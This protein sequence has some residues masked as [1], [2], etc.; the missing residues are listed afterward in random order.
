LI[1]T[2]LI[3]V[4]NKNGKRKQAVLFIMRVSLLPIFLAICGISCAF[5]NKVDG[6]EILD[7]KVTLNLPAEEI[8]AVLK[9]LAAYAEVGFTYSN[10]ILPAKQK[11]TLIAN[12]ERLGDLL[13][14]IFKPFGISFEV[15]GKQIVLTKPKS[16]NTGQLEHGQ[17]GIKYLKPIS[18]TV[19]SPDGTRLQG[20][21][22]T[23]EGTTRGTVTDENGHFEIEAN[24][25]DV[26][27]FSSVGYNSSRFKVGP[28][29]VINISLTKSQ[30]AMGEV[31]VT[32]LGI[33]REKKS[34]GYSV[35]GISGNEVASSNSPNVL[36]ALH[37]KMASVIVTDANGD[38]SGTTRIVMRG[39]NN[40]NPVG[41][42][43]P[44]IVVDGVPIN[45]DNSTNTSNGLYG[46][47]SVGS[48]QDWGSAINNINAYDIDSM[49]TL[50]GP[51]AA[52][53]YGERGGN[54]AIIINTKRGS[55]KPGLGLDYNFSYMG[56][57]IYKWQDF[58]NEF[59]AGPG[60]NQLIYSG[61]QANYDYSA[62]NWGPLPFPTIGGVQTLPYMSGDPSESWGPKLDGTSVKWWDGKMH[63]FSPIPES[64]TIRELFRNGLT[65][66]HN[67]SFSG[68]NDKGSIRVSLTRLDNNSVVPNSG[69][70]QTTVNL[71]GS[72]SIS[73]KVKADVAVTYIDVERHNAAYT[74]DDY[75]GAS[76]VSLPKNLS[77]YWP[78]GY[79][80][81]LEKSY[82]L[83]DGSINYNSFP[84]SF[85]FA[86]Q[87]GWFPYNGNSGASG[88]FWNLYNNNTDQ[89]QHE[90]LGS[91]GLTYDILPWLSLSG[92]IG[93]DNINM[94]YET[95]NKP[96]DAAGLLNGFYSR[97]L[98]RDVSNNNDVLLTF[99]KTGIGNLL[100]IKAS[101][102]ASNWSRDYYTITGSSGTWQFANYY[103]V[104]NYTGTPPVAVENYGNG[105]ADGPIGNKLINSVYGFVD[106]GYKGF[107]YLDIT[108]RNDWSSTLPSSA[109]SYFFPSVS[110][111]FVF[112]ELMHH[113]PHWLSF[114]KLR[115]SLASAA[116]D[117]PSY[118]SVNSYTTGS[119]AGQ[120][121]SSLQTTVPALTLKPQTTQSTELGANLAL[122]HNMVT[123]DLTYYNTRASNQILP[124]PIAAS[125]G[126]GQLTTNDGEMLNTGYTISINATPVQSGGF[127]WNVGLNMNHN[128]SKVVSISPYADYLEEGNIWGGYGPAIAA[129]AGDQYGTIYGWDYVYDPSTNKPILDNNGQ[130]YQSTGMITSTLRNGKYYY[131]PKGEIQGRVPV[132]NITPKFT[133][134]FVTSLSYK[135]FSLGAVLDI[136]VGGDMWWGD[137]GTAMTQGLS[138]RTLYEREGHGLPWKV[139][140]PASP[141]F[142]QSYNIGV[143]LPGVTPN[144][145]TP[146]SFQSNSNVVNYIYKYAVYSNWGS[147][148][149][150]TNTV[151]D[152]SWVSLRELN[153]RYDLPSSL[154]SHLKIFQSFSVS[155]VGRNLLY[156]YNS[157]PDHINPVS[158]GAGNAQGIE[159]GTM[160][161]MRSYGF[162]IHAGF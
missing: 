94:D 111:S 138:P 46:H 30:N 142:N 144:P 17:L 117:A 73:K 104:N 8:K 39:N 70:N 116:R 109:W 110:G 160:P 159:F 65:A 134:G 74:G 143:I 24:Q 130:Y 149:I 137:Y 35:Q 153:I 37:G 156:L 95:K 129:K 21:S 36:D 86:P 148:I 140:D 123:I 57:R 112:T 125:S 77:Y 56:T 28:S 22:V 127:I 75:N 88:V 2:K 66:T 59:G 15:I 126:A 14:K 93:M 101:V 97:T 108:A 146:G 99:H 133:G 51:A 18:G 131:D 98:G 139:T 9:E 26:L 42:N 67:V 80:L 69:R 25:G 103:S 7:K 54:G 91:I 5:A 90:L 118:L 50:P 78:R 12:D 31:V 44:L 47:N 124:V 29:Q 105:Y 4:M 64:T 41:D 145:S 63:A 161:M 141:N 132:G 114:G 135:G 40:L 84:N 96:W 92:R 3:K 19:T 119:F 60:G 85:N 113:K 1:T 61:A 16:E 32:A 71:G 13:V 151:S 27:V 62:A 49:Y 43:Q 155:L 68:A 38:G 48:S 115:A 83:P 87:I 33:K 45:N 72:L 34:L 79:D 136:K 58:Q 6:Q 10:H 150:T 147:N 81:S 102:G 23:I 55:N 128:Y 162:N 100:D 11:I 89:T 157:A 53:L 106:L 154:L 82:Q 120:G 152:D 52:A 121:Y 122:F 107:L 158:N 76:S 20:I